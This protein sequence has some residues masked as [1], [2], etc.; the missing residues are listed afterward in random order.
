[1]DISGLAPLAVASLLPLGDGDYHSSFEN[2]N[3]VESVKA[4]RTSKSKDLWTKYCRA[5]V[6]LQELEQQLPD[7]TV[8]DFVANSAL[9]REG[10]QLL[11][12]APAADAA[13]GSV[14]RARAHAALAVPAV[15]QQNQQGVNPAAIDGWMDLGR[16]LFRPPPVP[17]VPALSEAA[18][19]WL[20][21]ALGVMLILK[22]VI[23]FR[24]FYHN[25]A[26]VL[27]FVTGEVGV[28]SVTAV[29]TFSHGTNAV[30]PSVG[31]VPVNPIGAL[32]FAAGTYFVGH[33]RLLG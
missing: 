14:P 8:K 24:Y 20:R 32:V 2:P 6:A 1:M 4:A 10:Q 31:L 3:N 17:A 7:K 22:P 29:N 33:R 27:G 18:I 21:L 12:P 19:G 28:S 11:R 30:S 13:A 9:R 5:R 23:L 16:K 25:L 26:E 15:P